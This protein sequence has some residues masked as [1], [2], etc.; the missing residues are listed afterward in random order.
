MN[1]DR[2]IAGFLLIFFSG[3]V[4]YAINRF[5]AEI[6]KWSE[7]AK[8][9]AVMVL[10]L[11]FLV[12]FSTNMLMEEILDLNHYFKPP[13]VSQKAQ[14]IDTAISL[15]SVSA[16][17]GDTVIVPLVTTSNIAGL[18]SG[19]LGIKLSAT[20]TLASFGIISGNNEWNTSISQGDSKSLINFSK[21]GGETIPAGLFAELTVTIPADAKPG[22]VALDFDCNQTHLYD[23]KGSEIACAGINGEIEILADTDDVQSAPSKTALL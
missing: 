12:G 8:V 2:I 6:R 1:G 3:G 14:I 15:G 16:H 18:K 7:S 20:L 22:K 10:T 9:S 5:D 21:L 23:G 13:P 17:P 19:D 11:S 4:I